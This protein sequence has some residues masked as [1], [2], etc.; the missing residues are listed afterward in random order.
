M[1][2][3]RVRCRCESRCHGEPRIKCPLERK[4]SIDGQLIAQV[5][6]VE[7]L[8]DHVRCWLRP[9][10]IDLDHVRVAAQGMGREQLDVGTQL[11]GICRR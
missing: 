9:A 3:A 4:L 8:H 10:A 6:A 2:D 1:D 11:L 7:V 5:A